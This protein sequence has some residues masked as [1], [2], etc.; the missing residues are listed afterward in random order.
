VRCVNVRTRLLV[1]VT[2]VR[3]VE[4]RAKTVAKKGVRGDLQ[5]EIVLVQLRRFGDEKSRVTSQREGS[6]RTSRACWSG[7]QRSHVLVVSLAVSVVVLLTV[8][9][10]VDVMTVLTVRVEGVRVEILVVVV[11][12]S[13]VVNVEIRADKVDVVRI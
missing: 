11:A 12:G 3:S 2:V 5:E 4:V 6:C 7:G 9:L 10:G 1:R 13:V 8:V